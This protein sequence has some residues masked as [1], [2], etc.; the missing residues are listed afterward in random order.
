MMERRGSTVR[1]NWLWMCLCMCVFVQRGQLTVSSCVFWLCKLFI[2]NLATPSFEY[3]SLTGQP[4][5]ETPGGFPGLTLPKHV[6]CHMSCLWNLS[7]EFPLFIL[8]S[9]IFYISS[10]SGLLWFFFQI[11]LCVFWNVAHCSR[12]ITR[13]PRHS[14]MTRGH[15]DDRNPNLEN[16]HQEKSFYFSSISPLLLLLSSVHPSPLILMVLIESQERALLWF[17]Y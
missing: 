7:E 14:H 12:G 1:M 5:S 6:Q 13:G 3:V 17:H 11:N 8:Y 2:S 10:I 9:S 4:S 16:G 15:Q